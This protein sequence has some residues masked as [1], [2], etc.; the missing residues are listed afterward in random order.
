MHKSTL[1]GFILDGDLFNNL[2]QRCFILPNV[3]MTALLNSGISCVSYKCFNCICLII[4]TNKAVSYLPL[5]PAIRTFCIL[6]SPQIYIRNKLLSLGGQLHP[7]FYY[8]AE[9]L[10]ELT[11]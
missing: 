2:A 11:I 7:L 1:K 9:H 3:S 8:S 5:S 4:L 10:Y 6:F